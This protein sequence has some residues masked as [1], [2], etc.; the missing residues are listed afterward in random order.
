[1][2]NKTKQQRFAAVN[3]LIK[4]IAT[5]GRCIFS[6]NADKPNN[7]ENPFIASMEIDGCGK[8]WFT[9]SYTRKCI[10]ILYG[11]SWRYFTH[12]GIKRLVEFFRNHITRGAQ[13]K[14]D[15]FDL[16]EIGTHGNTVRIY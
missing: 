9:D 5:C 14:S 12:G 11:Y 4:I 1:M 6:E 15:C 2:T 13:I 8:V 7:V 10:Y 16:G 3:K